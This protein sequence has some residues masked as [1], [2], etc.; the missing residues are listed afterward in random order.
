[1]NPLMR[2]LLTVAMLAGLL[3]LESPALAQTQ[4]LAYV[5]NGGDDTVSVIDTATNTVIA[6]VGVGTTPIE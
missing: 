4:I 3:G 5:A 6:T 2:T 1:M